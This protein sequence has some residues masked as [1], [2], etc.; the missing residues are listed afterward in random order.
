M[1]SFGLCG[2]QRTGKTRL[3][4]AFAE[5]ANIP[6]VRTTVSAVFAQ[7]GIDP[8]RPMDTQTRMFIQERVWEASEEIWRST[9]GPWI[10]DR[11]PLDL[12][13]YAMVDIQGD[14]AFDAAYLER[15]TGRCMTVVREVFGAIALVQPG[16][17]L[18]YEPGK[19]ALNP[20]YIEHINL[21]LLGAGAMCGPSVDFLAMPR[22][23]LDLQARVGWLESRNQ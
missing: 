1:K 6:F 19:G 18:V 14:T 15:Y 9:Q 7:H 21:L 16:I 8:S 4:T 5:K 22:E 2:A 12:L 17:K 20:A 23:L 13:A 3:A 10:T 11:T